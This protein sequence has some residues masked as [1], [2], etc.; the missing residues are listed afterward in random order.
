LAQKNKTFWIMTY[1]TCIL[2]LLTLGTFFSVIAQSERKM[3]RDGNTNYETGNFIDAEINYKKALEKNSDLL[4]AQFNLGDAL[5]KQERFDEALESFEK[6]CAS[7]E[8][9]NLKAN[10]LHNKG[11]VLLSQQDLEGA[12]ESYKDALRINP[13]DNET[14]YNYTY[15]KKL[16]DEQQQQQQQQNQ[17]QEQNEDN[18][19]KKKEEDKEQNEEGNDQEDQKNEGSENKD[20]EN[21][22]NDDDKKDQQHNNDKTEQDQQDNGQTDGEDSNEENQGEQQKPQENRLSPEEAQRLLD[23]LN[24]QEEKVQDKMK[25][26]KL[27]GAKVKIEKDW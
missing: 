24:Q 13:K 10:A 11:N 23:A 15:V 27:K 4:E 17:D 7:T 26:H 16:L 5:V 22:D 9:L 25:K 14:R 3:T 18:Q 2:F 12:I 21:S 20:Q 1:K 8:D 19:E 6:V